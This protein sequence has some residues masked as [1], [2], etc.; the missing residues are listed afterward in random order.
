MTSWAESLLC[1]AESYMAE[2]YS[3][4]I[5]FSI[6][7]TFFWRSTCASGGAVVMLA[8]FFYLVSFGSHHFTWSWL[9]LVDPFGFSWRPMAS[10][11]P[12][13]DQ[14]APNM[15]YPFACFPIEDRKKINTASQWKHIETTIHGTNNRSCFSCWYPWWAWC[16]SIPLQD[17]HPKFDDFF[18]RQK[19]FSY[20]HLPKVRKVV[21]WTNIKPSSAK[22]ALFVLCCHYWMP[23]RMNI[24]AKQPGCWHPAG[25]H[26]T[27][28]L[29]S[30]MMKLMLLRGPKQRTVRRFV[31]RLGEWRSLEWNAKRHPDCKTSQLI[32][33]ACQT[34]FVENVAAQQ[35][36]L[37][38][39]DPVPTT[40]KLG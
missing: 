2:S 27:L 34:S 11:K 8:C 1:M 31:E 39:S 9:R 17:R 28:C 18:T 19:I 35:G 36:A 5:W 25:C 15:F 24:A 20:D 3:W 32:S 4:M 14:V 37:L 29:I 16:Q 30:A 23:Y 13:C 33:S 21:L 6:L 26:W 22:L 40:P 10:R 38:Q 12:M 7:Q